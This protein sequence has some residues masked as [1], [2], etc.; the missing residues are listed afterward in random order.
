MLKAVI[1]DMDG[2]II[3][4]EHVYQK[5]ELEMAAS[6]GL[7]VSQE[8]LSQ[9]TGIYM[10][11]MWRELAQ[12]YGLSI[13]IPLTVKKEEALMRDYYRSGELDVIPGSVEL[14]K[15][16]SG[17]GIRCAIATSSIT[18]SAQFVISRLEL[19]PYIRV[20]VSSSMVENCKP[21]P[22]VFLKC[23]GKLNVEADACIAIEDSKSGCIAAKAAGIR[24]I[25]YGS[26]ASCG[27]DL[28]MAD[29]IVDD[30][31]KIDMEMLTGL[32]SRDISHS[33]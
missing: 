14:I 5:V 10:D 30:M 7:Q 23:I 20:L 9:Y 32:L 1:F 21:S 13:D 4:S 8:E 19:A 28:S 15:S 3:N 22:D 27:Q 12:K 17:L 24:V 33:D 25:A 18:E 26:P 11:I 2:V 6:L 31:G 29:L 16:L